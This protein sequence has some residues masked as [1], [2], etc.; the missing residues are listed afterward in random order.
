MNDNDKGSTEVTMDD[1]A[2]NFEIYQLL[3]GYL[4]HC[5]SRLVDNYRVF[6]TF[7]SLLIPAVTAILVYISKND[8]G[9][10]ENVVA[11]RIAVILICFFG[12][13]VTRQGEG[14]VRRVILD[15]KVR[16]NQITRL[17]IRLK[18]LYLYP[19]IEGGE[20]FF[21]GKTLPSTVDGIRDL[22]LINFRKTISAT[23]AYRRSSYAIY[24][25]Y[26]LIVLFS[27]YPLLRPL[28]IKLV[29]S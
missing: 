14:I 5:H 3:V 29:C 25:A 23:D 7:N 4:Q 16:M 22:S 18:G 15:S 28:L 27:V 21:N 9:L 2:R 26:T 17:E 20:F 11:L 12:V 1:V 10:N 6:L 19:F 13:F 8:N 24:L